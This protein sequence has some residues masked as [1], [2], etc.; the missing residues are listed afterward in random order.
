MSLIVLPSFAL[1]V[2]VGTSSSGKST[3]ARKHFLPTQIVSS[4]ACRA[5]VGDDENDQTV[6]DAA[7]ELLFFLLE[8]RLSL[9]KLCVVDATNVHPAWRQPFIQIAQRH[10]AP[11]IAI[12]LDVPPHIAIARNR[13][14]TDRNHMPDS[15]ILEQRAF[16]MESIA[17]IHEEGFDEVMVLT[18]EAIDHAKIS[19]ASAPSTGSQS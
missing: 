7:F 19:V 18:G 14:R 4:D 9:E 13:Q 3:F 2:L 6:T 15:V 17:G 8:K 5:M 10:H 11:L 12:V 1:V 16:F